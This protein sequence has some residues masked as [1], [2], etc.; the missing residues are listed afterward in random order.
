MRATANHCSTACIDGVS[1]IQYVKEPP[2]RETK[3]RVRCQTER[4]V[5][6]FMVHGEVNCSIRRSCTFHQT[7]MK[8][9]EGRVKGTFAASTFVVTARS[10]DATRKI[11][12]AGQVSIHVRVPSLISSASKDPMSGKRGVF[13]KGVIIITREAQFISHPPR[14]QP[15]DLEYH[16]CAFQITAVRPRSQSELQSIINAEDHFS[17]P[18]CCSGAGAFQGMSIGTVSW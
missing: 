17:L 1:Y 6:G 3:V 8:Q 7:R 10:A 11:S 12:S 16:F 18:S 4:R 13:K 5:C 14:K 2:L 9:V 15:F